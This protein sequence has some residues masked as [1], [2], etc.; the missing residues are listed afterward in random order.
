[1]KR[2]RDIVTGLGLNLDLEII[3]AFRALPAAEK[4]AAM[5]FVRELAKTGK[6]PAASFAE[7][8]RRWR[9]EVAAFNA[10]RGKSDKELNGI[11]SKTFRATEKALVKA[12]LITEADYLAAWDFIE[13]DFADHQ[14][15]FSEKSILALL[16]KCRDWRPEPSPRLRNVGDIEDTICEVENRAIL[17]WDAINTG[18]DLKADEQRWNAYSRL[19]GDLLDVA[20]RL[21]EW[22]YKDDDATE[23][24]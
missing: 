21:K 19:G 1:M 6:R 3:E 20:K 18:P 13:E 23:G 9:Y 14:D 5:E 10:L 4:P 17:L 22:F 8:A 11:A 15:A 24:R 2:K 7:L 16:H 12:P